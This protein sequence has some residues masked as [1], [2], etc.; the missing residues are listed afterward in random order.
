MPHIQ[1]ITTAKEAWDAL[2]DLFIGNERMQ[3]NRLEEVCNEAKGF[4]IFDGEEQDDMYRQFKAL[5]TTFRDLGAYDMDH[6]WIKRKYIKA[7][8]PYEEAKL[9][10]IKGRYKF[11]EMSSNDVMQEV[12]TLKVAKKTT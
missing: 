9:T 8:L 6:Y 4:H 7:L 3:S 5:A 10:N 1:H 11:N 12:T 2:A